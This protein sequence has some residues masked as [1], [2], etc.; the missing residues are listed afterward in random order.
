MLTFEKFAG[1]NNT[2]PPERLSNSELITATNVDV[3]MTG[4]LLR[5]PGYVQVSPG[6][7][8]NIWQARGFMLAT[9]DGGALVALKGGTTTELHPALGVA[10]VWYC[11]L[12]DGRT[13]FSNGSI[14][15]ITDGQTMTGWGVEV[16]ASVGAATPVAGDL[17][18]GDYRYHITHVRLSDGLEGGAAFGPVIGLPDGGILLTGLPTLAGHKTN[19]YL[20]GANGDAAFLAGSTL[21]DSFSYLG[22]NDALVVPL[23]TA[24]LGAPPAGTL[25]AFWRGRALMADGNVLRASMSGRWELFDAR[26]DFKQFPGAITLIQPVAAGIFVGTATELAFLAGTDFDSLTYRRA[27]S[28]RVILGS[29]VRVPA[30]RIG[31][32][33]TD[34]DA[35][36]CMADGRLVAG[37][38]DGSTVLVGGGRYR[39]NESIQ[40]VAAVF[41]E[42]NGI[43]QYIAVPQ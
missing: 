39:V 18:S 35:M 11:N 24:H 28:G 29:G 19:I 42:S 34:G 26:K 6:C 12:P 21:T 23:R 14:C 9:I 30:N 4:E 2:L 33:G 40:Q 31:E 10:R 37:L 13:A 3:G 1:V 20:T 17:D 41:R 25:L 8:K 32:G 5:R 15:G 27:I 7:H 36:F 43:P 38:P 16:P 22:K